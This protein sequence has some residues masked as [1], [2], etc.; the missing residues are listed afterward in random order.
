MTPATPPPPPTPAV[1][2]T[3]VV[4]KQPAARE[5]QNRY[6]LFFGELVT[7][8]KKGDQLRRLQSEE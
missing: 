3:H 6:K 4:V 5:L 1:L 2:V 7:T 8:I